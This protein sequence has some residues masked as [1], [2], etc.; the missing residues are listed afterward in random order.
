VSVLCPILFKGVDQFFNGT[1]KTLVRFW[2]RSK[3]S[4]MIRANGRATRKQLRK[5]SLP[6]F[7]ANSLGR[8]K[9]EDERSE[10]LQ[11]TTGATATWD[12]N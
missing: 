4:R 12:L 10:S 3:I 2:P 9:L 7:L 6:G 8:A 1:S 11:R 5:V